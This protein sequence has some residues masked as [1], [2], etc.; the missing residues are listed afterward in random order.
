[1]PKPRKSK[2][3][4]QKLDFGAPGEEDEEVVADEEKTREA[5]RKKRASPQPSTTPS[6]NGSDA[7]RPK[8]ASTPKRGKKSA[9]TIVT[10]AQSAS[11]TKKKKDAIE[12]YVPIH[13]HK[14]VDYHRKGQAADALSPNT[15]K[16]F[17]LIEQHYEI[18]NDLEQSRAYGPLSGSTYEERVITAYRLGKLQ[19]VDRPAQIICTAC[20]GLGHQ[21][22]GC[23]TL[24]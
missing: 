23:P 2:S 1:M 15:L 6:G 21:R 3:Q 11:K 5:R 10:P 16:A 8:A 7:K 24:L 20:A 22:D 4:Q 14:N 13:I 17:Q 19:A 12:E 9:A 18:P